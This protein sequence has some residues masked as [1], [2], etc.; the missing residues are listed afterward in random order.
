MLQHVLDALAAIDDL[1][2]LTIS[3]VAGWGRS[4]GRG[5][6]QPVREAGHALAAKSKV[7][8][9][10]PDDMVDRVVHAIVQAGRTGKPGDGKVFVT[11]VSSAVRVR[12]GEA[13]ETAL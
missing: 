9:V 6:A 1:P 2:G 12:T 4:R 13:G 8:I 10:V 5:A 7:E 3:Q 11:E